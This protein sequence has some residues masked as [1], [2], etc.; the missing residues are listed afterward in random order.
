LECAGC[1]HFHGRRI[2]PEVK[3]KH[4]PASLGMTIALRVRCT[5]LDRGRENTADWHKDQRYMEGKKPTPLF[6][7]A[8]RA[9]PVFRS[10]CL[11]REGVSY[12]N[13]GLA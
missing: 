3:K 10:K 8:D 5:T 4:I 12:S 7:G 11:T 1:R 2:Q 9:L 13:Q 6:A